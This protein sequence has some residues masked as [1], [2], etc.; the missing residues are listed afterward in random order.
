MVP[1]KD[2]IQLAADSVPPWTVSMHVNIQFHH[3]VSLA[4]NMD[5]AAALVR[6][7]IEMFLNKAKAEADQA[8]IEMRCDYLVTC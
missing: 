8:G 7:Q 4:E 5:A 6:S 3:K 1:E 2:I